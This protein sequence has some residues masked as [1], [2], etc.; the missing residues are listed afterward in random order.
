MRVRVNVHG[1][2]LPE[3]LIG[4]SLGLMV[5]AAATAAY[6]VSRQTWSNM[7]AID[8]VHANARIAL[9]KI[10]EHAQIAGAAYLD[11]SASPN[12]QLSSNY[13]A[14][15]PDLQGENGNKADE[16]VALGHWVNVYDRDCQG[17][18]PKGIQVIR[19][20]FKLNADK[21]LT[22]KDLS[23]TSSTYQA[24]AEGVEDFQVRYAQAN[25]A[26]QTLQWKTADQVSAMSQVLAIEVC[27]RV[28]SVTTVSNGSTASQGCA[29]E[30]VA[31]DGRLRRV[32]RRVITLRNRDGLLP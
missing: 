22:C 4:L 7:A 5:I 20:D 10:R 11:K 15:Q 19:N 2:T 13:S 30:T 8:A 3:L 26:A 29:G 9:R 31:A 12:T 14:G 25:P 28:A 1:Y 21:E 17:N 18:Q 24:L 32:F 16:H 6:G 23:P 27:L